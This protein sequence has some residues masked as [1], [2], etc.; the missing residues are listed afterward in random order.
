MKKLVLILLFTNQFSLIAYSQSGNLTDFFPLQVGNT[1]VYNCTIFGET[2]GFCAKRVKLKVMTSSVI[3]GKTY[4][5]LQ[6]TVINVSGSC[7]GGGFCTS[8]PVT[9]PIR[10]DSVTG[11]LLSYST[12]GGCAWSPNEVMVDS[13]RARLHDTIWTGCQPPNQWA[14]YVCTDTNNIAVCGL[15]RQARGYTRYMFEGGGGRSYVKGIGPYAASATWLFWDR[16]CMSQVSFRGSV[17]NG[18]VC[19]DTSM[20]V[21][22]HQISTE[23]PESFA[24]YQNYPNPFNPVTKIRFD[25][26]PLLGEVSEGRGGLVKL[27]IFDLLG[28][29]ITTLVNE[30]LGPGTYEVSWDATNYP[31]GVYFCKLEGGDY[32]ESKKMVLSK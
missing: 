16:P 15:S 19:G 20:L 9:T 28:K 22:I 25:I 13:F 11:N 21:G 1:W 7:M 18:V 23:V 14:A 26:S 32:T 30:Q 3:N 10:I 12:S 24:L 5:Q 4:Y 8:F 27:I 29:E 6:S 2:C 31:S 17:I